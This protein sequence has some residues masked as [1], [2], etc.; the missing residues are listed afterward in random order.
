MA[1]GDLW[2][3][4]IT[5]AERKNSYRETKGCASFP[6]GWTE[7]EVIV[8]LIKGRWAGE[9]AM[10][11]NQSELDSFHHFATHELAHAGRDL[12]L[13]ELIRHWHEQRERSETVQSIRRGV[14]DA[15]A[16]RLHDL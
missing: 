9:C 4:S 5:G 14:A 11:V 12:E 7:L 16:G 3:Q 2:P 13:E 15:D 10:T 6:L 1:R 8:N